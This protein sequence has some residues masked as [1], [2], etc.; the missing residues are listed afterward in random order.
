MHKQVFVLPEDLA[1]ARHRRT[2]LES[3]IKALGSEFNDA[4]TQSSET[5]HDNAPFEAVRDKQS[6]LAA[7]LAGL[8]KV[9]H[10][11]AV[12]LPKVAAGVVGYG[13]IVSLRGGRIYRIAGDWT[14]YAGTHKGGVVWVSAQAP[15][16]KAMIGKKIGDSVTIGVKRFAIEEIK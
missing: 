8:K 9:I 10:D 7:E 11:A 2:E 3:E 13:S 5:W 6:V 16:A 15:V 12:R 14:P 1:Y 4:F